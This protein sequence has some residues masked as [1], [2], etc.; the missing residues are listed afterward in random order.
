MVEESKSDEPKTVKFH[1]LKSALF[2]VIHADGAFGGVTPSLDI[3][4]GIYSQRPALP[5]ITTHEITPNGMVGQELTEERIAK[6]GIVREMEAGVVLDLKS[7]TAMREWLDE[8]I[9]MLSEA[10]RA[11]KEQQQ[12]EK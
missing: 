5:D 9:K 4:M 6:Q 10:Q 11:V 2:R 7:A 3:F 1:Y 12:H 8:K